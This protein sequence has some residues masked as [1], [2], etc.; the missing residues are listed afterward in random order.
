VSCVGC[1][2]LRFSLNL[3]MLS[4]YFSCARNLLATHS[5]HISVDA[6]LEYVPRQYSHK[7]S[8]ESFSSSL[9]TFFDFSIFS[10]SF[11]CD[12]VYRNVTYASPASFLGLFLFIWSNTC[13]LLSFKAFT[14]R[15]LFFSFLI[16]F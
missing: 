11:F 12:S 16:T 1:I 3:E 7:V 14:T 8:M 4:E 13:V 6:L 10:V 5:I 2:F 15:C 9:L